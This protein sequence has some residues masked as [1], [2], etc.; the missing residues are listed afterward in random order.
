MQRKPT[1]EPAR[2]IRVLSKTS[3]CLLLTNGPGSVIQ[4]DL[5]SPFSPRT[6]VTAQ[7][8]N[9]LNTL[10]AKVTL[11]VFDPD[12]FRFTGCLLDVDFPEPTNHRLNY[13]SRKKS[14]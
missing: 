1:E 6:Y 8:V 3:V 13:L 9:A 11:G 12:T 2:L 14:Q 10:P 4:A 5:K 7:T